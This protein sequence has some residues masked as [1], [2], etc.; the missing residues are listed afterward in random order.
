[1]TP[2]IY[3]GA[4]GLWSLLCVY[5]GARMQHA[6]ESLSHPPL[7]LPTPAELK[8]EFRRVTGFD[9]DIPTNEP[10]GDAGDDEARARA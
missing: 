3:F 9:P 6:K 8:D 2:L 5:Y 10:D 7:P 1:M 4:F